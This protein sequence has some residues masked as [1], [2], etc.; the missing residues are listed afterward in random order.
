[1][2]YLQFDLSQMPKSIKKNFK[3]KNIFNLWWTSALNSST[4]PQNTSSL[5]IIKEKRR[6][7][8]EESSG[9]LN[10]AVNSQVIDRFLSSFFF[11]TTTVDCVLYWAIYGLGQSQM[12]PVISSLHYRRCMHN[13]AK[14]RHRKMLLE[15]L[16]HHPYPIPRTTSL[17]LLFLGLL[18]KHA[19]KM[20]QILCQTAFNRARGLQFFLAPSSIFIDNMHKRHLNWNTLF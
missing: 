7:K 9:S 15:E 14:N 13:R 16:I 17:L 8:E 20:L 4:C 11:N 19:I 12:S 10:T 18:L 6:K 5:Q 3:R 1:M 2:F